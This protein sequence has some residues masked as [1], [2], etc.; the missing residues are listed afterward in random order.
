MKFTKG[1]GSASCRAASCCR[2][3]PWCESKG[4]TQ[5][6][7]YGHLP[8][9]QPRIPGRTCCAVAGTSSSL[10]RIGSTRCR[11]SPSHTLS[12]AAVARLRTPRG[13]LH[14]PGL[15]QG[16]VRVRPSRDAWVVGSANLTSLA[17]RPLS[18]LHPARPIGTSVNLDG[19]DYSNAFMGQLQRSSSRSRVPRSAWN[20]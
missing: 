11:W 17:H 5:I 20:S 13:N 4:G 18:R 19:V 15:L 12:G 7:P 2:T 14:R 9:G 10:S 3:S 6:D 1:D 8:S 16:A